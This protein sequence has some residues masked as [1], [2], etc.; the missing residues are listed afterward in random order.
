MTGKTRSR[1]ITANSCKHVYS[2]ITENLNRPSELKNMSLLLNTQVNSFVRSPLFYE[3]LGAVT[4][5]A[6]ILLILW[7]KQRNLYSGLRSLPSPSGGHWFL[8]NAPQ[9]LN[10]VKEKKFFQLLFDWAKELGPM[11]VY[12]IGSKPGVILSDPKLIESTI[13][14]GMRDGSL[15]RTQITRKAYNDIAGPILLGESGTEWQWR[16]KAWNPEFTPKVLPKHFDTIDR[17]CFQIIET[18]KE[19]ASPIEVKADPLF[20]ELTTRVI[21]CLLFGIPVDKNRSTAEGPPLEIEKLYQAMSVLTYRILRVAT[22]EKIWMKYLPIK[23]SQEYWEGRKYVETFLI[24]RVDL[25]LQMRDNPNKNW[26]DICPLFKQSML[27]KIAAKEPKY[28]RDSLIAE[29][30]EFLIAGTDTTAH[31]L[32]FALGELSL[33]QNVFQKARTIVDRTWETY[34]GITVESLKDLSYIRAI[35]KETLRLYSVSSGSTSLQAERDTIVGDQPIPRGT[36]IFWS[37]IAAGRDPSIYP[38]PE[39][40]IPERWLGDDGENDRLII[41]AFGSGSHRCLGENLAILEATVMLTMLLRY[42]DW[43]L[44]NGRSSLENLQQNLL[45]YPVD[46][47]PTK[48]TVRELARQTVNA[49]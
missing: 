32:S 49:K 20:V 47:M 17:A 27:V 24:P 29:S 7:W 11:Y 33:N 14:N 48:F 22:G 21:S 35:F 30:I 41:M 12:W 23:S 25:A 18:I 16:R 5:L 43:E 45:I 46:R 40:F 37:T 36:R 1:K 28:D 15:V 10:S 13:I 39:E 3:I 19:T 6:V 26:E 42:F 2:K 31:S 9:L 34:G 4:V 38:N 8:G 44:V